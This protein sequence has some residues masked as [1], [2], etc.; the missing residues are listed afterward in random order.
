M[1]RYDNYPDNIRDF[2]D[3][4]RSPFYDSRDEDWKIDQAERLENE[5]RDGLRLDDYFES[6]G[7]GHTTAS[8][9]ADAIELDISFDK[10]L[11]RMAERA[12]EQLFDELNWD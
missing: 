5:Y 11:Y 8:V 6:G 9:L 3:D 7:G 1:P 2:D 4:P 12:A 10:A